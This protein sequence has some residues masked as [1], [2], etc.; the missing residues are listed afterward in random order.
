[1]SMQITAIPSGHVSNVI[2]QIMPHLMKLAPR[3][4][5]RSSVDDIL[6]ELL[7]GESTVWL[8]F[9]PEEE[10]RVYGV[11][12]CK[13]VQYPRARMLNI[14]Y[15]AGNKLNI[16]Q[17]DMLN[18]LIRWAKDNQCVRI[19]FT[20]RAGWLKVLKPWNVKEAYRTFEIDFE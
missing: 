11:S 10:N 7:A 5:G 12:I 17:A 13:V 15:T 20:G 19:E 6:R 8:A 16:W 4:N 18:T 2:P 3:T 1:M 14:D 9:E